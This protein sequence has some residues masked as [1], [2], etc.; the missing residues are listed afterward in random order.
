MTAVITK[1][2]IITLTNRL[3]PTKGA[4]SLWQRKGPAG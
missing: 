4:P 3:L 2:R 1:S